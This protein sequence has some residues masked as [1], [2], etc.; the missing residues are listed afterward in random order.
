VVHVGSYKATFEKLGHAGDYWCKVKY[1][2]GK[3]LPRPKIEYMAGV[4]NYYEREDGEWINFGIEDIDIKMKLAKVHY[5]EEDM[6]LHRVG[7][8]KNLEHRLQ[9]E[10]FW[11]KWGGVITMAVFVILI[12]I[13]LIVLF[14][15][16]VVVSDSIGKM[17]DAV[18][19]LADVVNQ[20]QT[21]SGSGLVP[22]N[23]G[24]VSI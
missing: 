22:V 11:Q 6:R 23:S 16:L 9:K 12:T 18:A 15:K 21:H 8:Q 17:A 14:N 7:I 4:F 20:A 19:K 3:I 1:G 10:G 24:G 13:C 5:L 2:G